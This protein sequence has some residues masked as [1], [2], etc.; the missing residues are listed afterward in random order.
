MEQATIG[1]HRYQKAGDVV[2]L[3]WQGN[4]SA[5][6]LKV[7]REVT[8]R[9]MQELG[10]AFTISDMSQ[11]T[12][13]DAGARKYMAEWGQQDGN[14]LITGTAVYG[15]S[16]ATRAITTLAL[17]AITL[18]GKKKVEVAFVK[19]EAEATRWVDEQRAARFPESAS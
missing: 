1:R 14:G 4:I 11:V 9:M 10:R 16:F 13:I 18:L 15:L 2:R 3:Q 12:G 5:D 19:D 8:T 17:N 6:D 7:M